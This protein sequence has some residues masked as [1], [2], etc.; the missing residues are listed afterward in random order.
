MEGPSP[1][2]I[3]NPLINVTHRPI[4]LNEFSRIFQCS[5]VLNRVINEANQ[6]KVN[7]CL[8][9]FLERAILLISPIGILTYVFA[10]L[11]Y[12]LDIQLF[13]QPQQERHTEY[14]MLQFY[15]K[16]LTLRPQ[17]VPRR[18]QCVS[19]PRQPGSDVTGN[20]D[21]WGVTHSLTHSH[22]AHYIRAIFFFI[23]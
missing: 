13:L 23:I 11:Y 12:M 4:C 22:Q 16:K 7:A 18:K 9:L 10:M 5:F 15:E 2:F 3:A 20:H 17:S 8:Q 19:Q 21:S 6:G 1:V 14:T